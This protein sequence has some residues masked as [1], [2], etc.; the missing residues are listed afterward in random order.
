MLSVLSSPIMMRRVVQQLALRPVPIQCFAS[1]AS[2][3]S[4][5]RLSGLP[6][7]VAD[8]AVAVGRALSSAGVPYA[9]AGAVACNAHGHKRATADVDVLINSEDLSRVGLALVGLG[10]KARF[11]GARRAM[12]DT[13]RGVDVDV[14][15]SGEFPGDGK[16]KPVAFP[17]VARIRRLTDET[18]VDSGLAATRNNQAPPFLVEE[19]PEDAGGVYVLPLVPLIEVKLASGMTAPHRRKDF[20][21]VQALITAN[22]LPRVFVNELNAYVKTDFVRLWD[23][24]DDARKS[25][26]PE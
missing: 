25:G 26:L 18:V 7:G 17:R 24:V 12:R 21:D 14:L 16:P 19:I 10:W 22:D 13:L 9:V 3:L 5:D 8:A 11:A 20:A 6:L 2:P 1:S 4:L 23:E 15:V